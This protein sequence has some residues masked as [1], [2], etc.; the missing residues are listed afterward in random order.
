[1][2]LSAQKGHMKIKSLFKILISDIKLNMLFM[3]LVKISES[4]KVVTG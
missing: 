2:A 3:I 4:L 1:M